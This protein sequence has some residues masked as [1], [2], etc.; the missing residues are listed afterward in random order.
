MKRGWDQ[1]YFLLRRL[2]K[3]YAE[4]SL[5]VLAY[6]LRWVLNVADMPQ[7][8]ASLGSGWQDAPTRHLGIQFFRR[9][10]V[11]Y[12]CQLSPR[13]ESPVRWDQNSFM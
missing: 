12:A 8:L 5:T 10:R 4:V 3:V 9:D 13:K 11:A 1:G 7:L 6:N 2:A